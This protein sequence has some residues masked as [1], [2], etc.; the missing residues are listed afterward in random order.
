MRENFPVTQQEYPFPEGV[1]LLSTTDTSSH[2]T[3]ANGAFVEVSGYSREELIGQAHN[4]VR[5]PDMPK[6]AFAD[7]WATLRAGLSWTALVKNRRKDGDHYWVRANATP[8]VRGGRV[9]GYMSVRT[10]PEAAE[11]RAAEQLYRRFRDGRAGGLRF[12]RGLLL[13]SGPLA[14]LNLFQTLSVRGRVMLGLLLALLPVGLGVALGAAAWVQALLLLLGLLPALAWME[15]QLVAPLRTIAEQAQTV[16]SGQ[17]GRMRQLDRLD[18]I[19]MILRSV[20]QAGLNLRSVVDDVSGQVDGLAH[21]SREIAEGNLDLSARTEAQASNLQQ[22]AS[23]MEQMTGTVKQSAEN[24]RT[25]S[26]LANQARE[27]AERGGD[28]VTGV[29]GTMQQITHASQ[30][31][32]DIIGVIDGIAFQTNILALN[33]AVEAARAGEQ[34]RG[35]AVV[36]SEVRSLAQ[37]SAEA[38]KE[39]KR[40][41]ADSVEKV[42]AGN[43]QVT[44][45]LG[46]MQGIVDQ[47]RQVTTLID[48]ISTATGEQSQ[49]IGQVNGA[50]TELDRM[51][52]Q[53]AALV[54]QS[55]A[56]AS[57]LRLQAE[58]LTEA[59]AVFQ[60]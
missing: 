34:G 21:A 48:E 50:V 9:T 11:V 13:R 16:A 44:G 45:A 39:V 22:T 46:A 47:V 55:A 59:C 38:A 17:P 53:N 57:S 52:Q 30:R 60:A 28:I 43:A 37:R 42:E 40:L 26:G 41:I 51:T 7:M 8:V 4:L 56:A 24:A 23:S 27:A 36:A 18:D 2:I 32:G 20:N 14:A 6:E 33:A 25:A 19:G 54:E 10:K 58:A 35:F 15:Q 5:H 31:I 12:H 29:A 3:Y 49:G 1:T